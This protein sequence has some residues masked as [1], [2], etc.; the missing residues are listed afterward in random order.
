MRQILPSDWLPEWVR[1]A[2]LAL[3]GLPALFLC[4]KKSCVVRTSIPV[5]GNFWLVWAMELQKGAEDSQNKEK[6]NDCHEV[7]TLQ[8]PKNTKL[9]N[10]MKISKSFLIL[11]KVEP[12]SFFFVF[13][14]LLDLDLI[15]V[16][17]NA[18]TG[19]GQY[20]TILIS[21]LVNNV[22]FIHIFVAFWTSY[23]YFIY[24]V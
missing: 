2:Y 7:I 6:V 16:H 23:T 10:K 11:I 21:Y 15:L 13:L 18:K 1:W 12:H 9:K 22:Y 20:P 8:K 14:V 4:L 17:K 5:V 24:L 3:L 19:L